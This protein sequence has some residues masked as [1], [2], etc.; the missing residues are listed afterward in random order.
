MQNGKNEK[1]IRVLHI[2]TN[3][4]YGGLENLLMN[5][6]RNI[7]RDIIQ[8]DFL[9][10]FSEKQDFEEE[11]KRLGGKL[12]II[13]PLNPFSIKYRRDLEIFFTDHP[14][15]R[16]VHCHLNCMS[17]L[18]LSIAKKCGVPIRIA[19]SHTDNQNINLKY[20]IKMIY[21]MRISRYATDLFAC[22][23][24]AGEWMFLGKPYR[25]LTNAIDS[26]KF[27]YDYI[28]SR[29]EKKKINAEKSLIIGHV[30]QFRKEKNQIFLID[31][32][33]EL[34]KCD[35]NALLIFVGKGEE[36]LSVQ[37][38]A[39]NLGIDKKVLFLGARQDVAEIMQMFDVFAFPSL[40]EG[41]GVV[42]I[43]A[44]AAGLPCVISDK[45]PLECKIT[46]EVYQLPLNGFTKEWA[47]TI[48]KASEKQRKNNYEIV[49]EKGYDI[50]ENAKWLER[51]YIGQHRSYT[52]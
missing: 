41:L 15:Y 2:V 9:T 23:K 50:L 18:P 7:D 36:M 35:E 49:K 6:Y 16:I 44:Q 40:H 13:R 12:F 33:C 46:D 42:A 5:Y 24:V 29:Y 26:K 31:V 10:H 37:K 51:Y 30:G 11:I 28:K 34:L 8:F 48:L 39:R 4:S 47:Y 1:T 17:G 38:R 3:M 19:H 27:S 21:R 32:L 52:E 22:S 14:E 25:I 45:V 20:P 43:E